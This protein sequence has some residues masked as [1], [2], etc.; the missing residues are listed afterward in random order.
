M[1]FN[2]QLL[3]EFVGELLGTFMLMF[4]GEASTASFHVAGFEKDWLRLCA[5]WAL[6]VFFGILVSIKL[7]GAHLNLAVTV[8]L[9]TLRKF[10]YK[11]IPFYF[12]GQ[13]IGA[14]LGTGLVHLLFYGSIS[15][16]KIPPFAWETGRGTNVGLAEAFFTEFILTG[17]LLIVI[18]IVTD[19]YI[20]GRVTTLKVG[21]VVGLTVF[22]IGIG[23]GYNSGFAINPSR[24]L[25]ARI[26]SAIANGGKAFS[27]DNFY[28]WVPIVGPITGATVLSVFYV[29][30]IRPLL[31]PPPPVQTKTSEVE[32]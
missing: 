26:V 6:A 12:L 19:E 17:V 14:I 9:A 31:T 4:M 3:V 24:D 11:K 13:L 8:S 29:Y 10:D 16:G 7:S 32:A 22:Y 5:G 30:L 28:F 15:N 20:C 18:L 2:R 27:G 21:S 1:E 25:G 23:F